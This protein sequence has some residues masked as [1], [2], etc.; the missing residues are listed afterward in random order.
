MK[1]TCQI[2]SSFDD[3][4][5]LYFVLQLVP[6]PKKGFMR[7][8]SPLLS[9]PLCMRLF[10]VSGDFI[11]PRTVNCLLIVVINFCREEEEIKTKIDG[12]SLT[13]ICYLL[14]VK[15]LGITSHHKEQGW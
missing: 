11:F 8:S 2:K 12:S 5:L 1:R 4:N 15:V 14:V 6:G 10:V 9:S 3:Q 13:V 7:L